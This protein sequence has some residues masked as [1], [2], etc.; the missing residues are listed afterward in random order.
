VVVLALA[1]A[2]ALLLR[3]PGSASA[4]WPICGCGHRTTCCACRRR[5]FEEN[6]PSEIASRLTA[7]T[8][9]IEQVVGSTVS[10]ALRNALTGIGGI[11]YLFT[12]APKLTG[13]LLLAIPLIILPI[14]LLGRRVRKLSRASQDRDRRCRRDGRRSARRDEDRPGLRSGDAAR[15][16]GLPARSRRR[17]AA[18]KRA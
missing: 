18:A 6:R 15:P 9:I 8:A 1:T 12:L 16:G 11:I 4:S 17:S 2:H 14:L 3:L 7:D 10:I 5:F 13:L